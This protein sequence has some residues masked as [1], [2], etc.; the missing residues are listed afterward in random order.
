MRQDLLCIGQA[1]REGGREGKKKAYPKEEHGHDNGGVGRNQVVQEE[2]EGGREEGE[3]NSFRRRC[4]DQQQRGR[5]EGGWEGG[6][7]GGRAGSYLPQRIA[8]L[9]QTQ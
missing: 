6:R 7:E 8:R 9:S 2:G 4:V 5:R 1:E 3:R